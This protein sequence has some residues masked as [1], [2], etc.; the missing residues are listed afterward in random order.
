[1]KPFWHYTNDQ[2]ECQK[3]IKGSNVLIVISVYGMVFALSGIRMLQT[4]H[5]LLT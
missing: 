3:L 2:T 1:M 4:L 5:K